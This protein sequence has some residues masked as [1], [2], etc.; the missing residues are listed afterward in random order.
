MYV[1]PRSEDATLSRDETSSP[2][3]VTPGRSTSA[4]F[5]SSQD[6]GPPSDSGSS[7]LRR[8]ETPSSTVYSPYYDC[9]TPRLRDFS[10]ELEDRA[11]EEQEPM[12]EVRNGAQYIMIFDGVLTRLIK[13]EAAAVDV[14]ELGGAGWGEDIDKVR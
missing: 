12:E 8:S 1:A 4:S 3:A 9:P 5:A 14:R 13:H 6:S 10:A 7:T 11:E 2:G